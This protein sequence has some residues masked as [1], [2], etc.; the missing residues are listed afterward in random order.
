MTF[1][2]TIIEI[3][4]PSGCTGCWYHYEVFALD[5]PKPWCEGDKSGTKSQVNAH[6]DDLIARRKKSFSVADIKSIKKPRVNIKLNEGK[7]E[8]YRG[9]W[10]DTKSR[11]FS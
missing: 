3:P 5:N 2:R 9:D 7:S 8:K 1:T 6:I 11:R 4:P 10:Q